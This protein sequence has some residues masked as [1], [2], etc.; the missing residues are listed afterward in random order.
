MEKTHW[1]LQQ[2]REHGTNMAP[3][4]DVIILL[5]RSV[6]FLTPL[7]TQ[8]TYEELIDDVYGIKYSEET[9]R[10]TDR[11]TDTDERERNRHMY[12][13]QQITH[14]HTQIK[15][16]FWRS[17]HVL[18]SDSYCVQYKTQSYKYKTVMFQIA[19]CFG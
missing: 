7:C 12:Q 11:Q 17:V 18:L 15:I 13:N 3:Q 4:I 6:D 9:D 19:H 8:L 5:D 10:Q 14:T 1:Q 2:G 16:V